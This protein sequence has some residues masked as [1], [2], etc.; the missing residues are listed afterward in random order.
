MDLESEHEKYLCQYFNNSPVFVIN[1]PSNLKAFYMKEEKNKKTV[2][3]FDLLVPGVG[4]LVGGSER[5][6]E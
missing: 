2:L 6:D 3:S 5:S 4:E 1:Y